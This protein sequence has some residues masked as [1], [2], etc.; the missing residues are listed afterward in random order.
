M[1]DYVRATYK[2]NGKLTLFKLMAD[3]GVNPLINEVDIIQDG[4][5]NKSLEYFVSNKIQ[6]DNISFIEV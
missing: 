6:Q 5:L 2:S 4:D 3:G 1:E